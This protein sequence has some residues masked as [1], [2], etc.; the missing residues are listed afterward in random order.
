MLAAAASRLAFQRGGTGERAPRPV[1]DVPP[2]ARGFARGEPRLGRRG[3][4]GLGAAERSTFHVA[5][6]GP[7]PVETQ[8]A[9]QVPESTPVDGSPCSASGS[10]ARKSYRFRPLRA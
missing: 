8:P 1:R 2:R 3:R 10:R 6:I 4:Q 5:N 9:V 7:T